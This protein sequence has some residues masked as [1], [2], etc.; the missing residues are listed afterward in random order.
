IPAR[1]A[2]SVRPMIESFQINARR[3]RVGSTHGSGL[4]AVRRNGKPPDSVTD[5]LSRSA[6]AHCILPPR[7]VRATREGGK[8]P[9]RLR[10]E[11]LDSSRITN[12]Q[13]KVVS[14]VL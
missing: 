7:G 3:G 12:R 4:H 1:S 10:P 14:Y 6:T 9:V 13:F 11:S 2:S 5:A 8:R